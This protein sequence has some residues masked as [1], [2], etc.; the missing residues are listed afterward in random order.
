MGPKDQRDNGFTLL[1]LICVILII[2]LMAA[3]VMP[4]LNKVR[5]IAVRTV[6][7]T[8]LKSLGATGQMYLDEFDQTFPTDPGQWLYTWAADSIEHPLGCRWHD[9]TMAPF[10]E[11]VRANKAYHGAM[12]EYFAETKFSCCPILSEVARKR[13]CDNPS[14]SR[15]IEIIPQ[16][17]YTLNGYLGSSQPGGVRTVSNIRSPGRVFFFAE[18]NS[19]SLRPD[20]PRFPVSWLTAPLSTKALDDT[21]LMI[22]PTPQADNCFATFHGGTSKDLSDG[23]GNLVYVDG[24]VDMLWAQQQ[25]RQVMHKGSSIRTSSYNKTDTDPAGNLAWAWAAQTPPADGWENQ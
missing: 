7:S 10:G 6:C 19:W 25:L 2:V 9:S 8:N 22:T 12:W 20:H 15:D 3:I 1:E 18:E 24:H 16:Y 5:R 21:V 23:G 17:N 4:S 13:G 14:H 11:L